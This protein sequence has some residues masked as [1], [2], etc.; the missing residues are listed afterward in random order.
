MSGHRRAQHCLQ[1]C[2]NYGTEHLGSFFP[3][4]SWGLMRQTRSIANKTK[5]LHFPFRVS[6]L[7]S[8]V[9]HSWSW[10][11]LIWLRGSDAHWTL[12]PAKSLRPWKVWSKST[13]HRTVST[14]YG[15]CRSGFTGAAPL[16]STCW[17]ES[18]E[19][20][21]EVQRWLEEPESRAQSPAWRGFE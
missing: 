9:F 5:P 18:R 1:Y 11:S 10:G 16:G 13:V 20:L 8:R 4:N 7:P 12:G 17:D 14:V 19:S 15:S 3:P 2:F 6:E 21:L